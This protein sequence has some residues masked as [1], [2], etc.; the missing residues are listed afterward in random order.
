MNFRDW[1]IREGG[2]GSGPKLTATGLNAGG[3]TQHG[4]RYRMSAK[5]ARPARPFSP[6]APLKKMG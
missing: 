2:K 3:M 6:I 1:L 5:P 4:M